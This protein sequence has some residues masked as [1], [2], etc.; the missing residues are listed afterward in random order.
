MCVSLKKPSVPDPALPTLACDLKRSWQAGVTRALKKFAFLARVSSGG[1]GTQ[2]G[3][4]MRQGPLGYFADMIV[5]PL[6]AGGLST[7]ALTHFTNYAL[8]RWLAMVMLGVAL[9]TLIE[10][11]THRVIYHRVPTFKNYHE[12]HHA[13]PISIVRASI[14][15]CTTIETTKAILASLHRSGIASLEHVSY[16]SQTSRSLLD[17]FETA[18]FSTK[19]P[20]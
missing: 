15:R 16:A 6:L 8:V 20:P 9:W 18:D 12:A 2:M 4:K 14:T 3:E 10:Y 19:T 7:F 11:G 13:D 5:S 1:A 17:D